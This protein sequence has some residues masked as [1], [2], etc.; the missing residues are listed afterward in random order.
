MTHAD[1]LTRY[2]TRKLPPC[3]TPEVEAEDILQDVWIEAIRSYDAVRPSGEDAL[4]K[5]LITIARRRLVTA[6][7]AD[8]RKKRS[9]GWLRQQAGFRGRGSSLIDLF[10][11]AA[12]E[13]RTPSHESA[14]REAL[15]LLYSVLEEMPPDRRQAIRGKYIDEHSV[16]EIALEM[17]K[18]QAAVRSL[19]ANGLRQMRRRLGSSGQFFSDSNSRP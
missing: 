6:I 2:I 14:T 11:L 3:L 7:R 15:E 19:L 13:R 16:E 18:S 17:D 9:G 8:L 5:W 12:R 4:L 1:E 10:G